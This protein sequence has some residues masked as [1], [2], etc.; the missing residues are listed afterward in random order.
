MPCGALLIG[1]KTVLDARQYTA[2]RMTVALVADLI[3][4]SRIEAAAAHVGAPLVVL[5]RGEDLLARLD[6]W[7]LVL[8]DLTALP[9]AE[10]IVREVKQRRPA[11]RVIGF[12]PHV[13]VQLK[14]AAQAA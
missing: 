6:Q 2:A 1:G 10:N 9:D 3:F 8:V 12:F 13:Q 7:R 5:R 4:A 11:L 14:R